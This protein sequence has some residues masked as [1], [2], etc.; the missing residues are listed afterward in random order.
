MKR[1]NKLLASCV[2]LSAMGALPLGAGGTVASDAKD[3]QPAP[4]K[5]ETDPAMKEKWGVE[6]VSLRRTAHG[7]M[8][9][10]RYKV[11]DA[12]KAA[13]L[14]VRKTKPNLVHQSSGKVLVVPSTAKLGPLRNSYAPKEGRIYWMFFGNA[15]DLVKA[16]DKVTVVIGEFRA[17]DLPVE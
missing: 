7:H 16:G 15:G 17:E 10:F 11:L 1:F 9:D 14:F 6:I 4:M 12:E 5:W 13:P 8:L 3:A 2:L